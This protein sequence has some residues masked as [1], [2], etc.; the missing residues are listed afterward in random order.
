MNTDYEINASRHSVVRFHTLPVLGTLTFQ[1]Q[2]VL[3]NAKDTDAIHLDATLTGTLTGT[4]RFRGATTFAADNP[5]TMRV[6]PYATAASGAD[7]TRGLLLAYNG[8]HSRWLVHTHV[9]EDD[10][11]DANVGTD[12][13]ISRYNDAGTRI[14]ARPLSIARAT[15]LT[16]IPTLA[17]GDFVP[18]ESGVAIMAEG[19]SLTAVT[20]LTLTTL[21][22][23]AATAVPL[24]AL[25]AGTV[26][27]VS[28]QTG[29][30]LYIT[31]NGNLTADTSFAYSVLYL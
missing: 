8:T 29:S 18:K 25:P 5:I 26:S 6:D 12:F 2:S 17:P 4:K 15:G 22:R 10:E 3:G 16:T 9:P 31:T 19:T 27:G 30:T 13:A 11:E 7:N 23:I 24:T 28:I 20:G 14:A 1:S 21:S